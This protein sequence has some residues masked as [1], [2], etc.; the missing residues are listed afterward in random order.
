MLMI[1]MKE[2]QT[3]SCQ[4]LQITRTGRF[5]QQ[6]FAFLPP[7]GPHCRKCLARK[8]RTSTPYMLKAGM[9]KAVSV[10]FHRPQMCE[11]IYVTMPIIIR[12]ENYAQTREQKT[13]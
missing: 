4:S 11:G 7:S 6:Y 9:R 1:A 2:K 8:P 3:F 5:N 12:I 10:G 13:G